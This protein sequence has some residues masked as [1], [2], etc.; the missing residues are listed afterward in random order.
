M[1][2]YLKHLSCSCTPNIK[3]IKHLL[4][5]SWYELIRQKYF[6][7]V[8]KYFNNLQLSHDYWGGEGKKYATQIKILN[9]K[10]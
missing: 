5:I 2:K 3:R 7:Y 6:Q 4:D 8:W 9:A 1:L 10:A